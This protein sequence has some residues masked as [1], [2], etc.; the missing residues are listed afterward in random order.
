MSHFPLWRHLD[1]I[2]SFKYGKQWT[3]AIV[4]ILWGNFLLFSFPRL[5]HFFINK[6]LLFRKR[7]YDNLRDK[8]WQVCHHTA[9]NLSTRLFYW[10]PKICTY[11]RV[12]REIIA[13]C[14]LN[15]IVVVVYNSLCQM[16][17]IITWNYLAKKVFVEVINLWVVKDVGS[18]MSSSL[19]QTAPSRFAK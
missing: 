17:G 15:I 18:R 5:F 12:S 16:T 1:L 2:Q 8:K 13:F 19:V 9:S 4:V 6:E 7:I 14:T 11:V 3:K 10:I